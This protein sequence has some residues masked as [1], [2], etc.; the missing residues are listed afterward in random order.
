[1]I[2]RFPGAVTTPEYG[3]WHSQANDIRGRWHW[4]VG[5]AHPLCDAP[6]TDFNGIEIGI[7]RAVNLSGNRI[8]LNR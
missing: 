1:V 6:A 2:H 8:V 5:L 4:Y 7:I 3:F